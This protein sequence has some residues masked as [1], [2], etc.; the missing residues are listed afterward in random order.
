MQIF[1]FVDFILNELNLQMLIELRNMHQHFSLET[2]YNFLIAIKKTCLMQMDIYIIINE[3]IS[4]YMLF[5]P[6]IY[7]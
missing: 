5:D 4:H 7:M 2:K 3:N 6:Y 1:I